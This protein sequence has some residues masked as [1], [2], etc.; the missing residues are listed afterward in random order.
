MASLQHYYLDANA[1]VPL[2]LSLKSKEKIKEHF[3]DLKTSLCSHGH[4]L[5]PSRMGQAASILIE[6]A[7][8]GI[9][10]LLGIENP[11]S[12]YFTHSC[13]ESNQWAIQLLN[14]VCFDY[15]HYDVAISPF[16]HPSMEKAV[17]NILNEAVLRTIK[18]KEDTGWPV[19]NFN[20]NHIVHIGVQ[21]EIGV[22]ADIEGLRGICDGLLISDIS[23]AVGKMEVDLN[24][25]QVDIATFGAHKFGGAS[26]VGFMYV[27]NPEHWHPFNDYGVSYSCDVPGTPNVVGIYTSYLALSDAMESLEQRDKNCKDFR[28][29]LENG[30]E[31]LGFDIICKKS[32]YRSPNTTFARAPKKKGAL[33]VSKLSEMGIHIGLG[34]ACGSFVVQDSHV[35]KGLGINESNTHFIRI[36]QYGDYDGSDADYVLNQIEKV[37]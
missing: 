14:S 1:H 37:L 18:V 2:R 7:R 17:H 33:L 25:S 24:K 26:G 30:L 31:A 3:D 8:A 9:S 23:Q 34:S 15:Y 21:S 4:P 36:S 28:R 10:K 20:T 19:L 22:I 35:M 16:E 5:S 11:T 6:E 13:T 32:D 27:K 29:I 12:L